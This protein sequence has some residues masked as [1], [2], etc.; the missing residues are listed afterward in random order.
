[1]RYIVF[2]LGHFGAALSIELVKLG[3]EVIGIDN[4]WS[5]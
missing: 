2:G 4:K 3:H 1:M 5:W